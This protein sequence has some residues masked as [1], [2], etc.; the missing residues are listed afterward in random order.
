MSVVR[1]DDV[2]DDEPN[3]LQRSCGHSI[4]FFSS[5]WPAVCAVCGLWREAARCDYEIDGKRCARE[6]RHE[7]GCRV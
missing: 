2:A 1:F 5:Q 3:E 4:V 6:A 7:G